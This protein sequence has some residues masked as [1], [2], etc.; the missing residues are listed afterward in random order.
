MD[1]LGTKRPVKRLLQHSGCSEPWW[2][3]WRRATDLRDI[4]RIEGPEG[5]RYGGG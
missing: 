4:I 3:G 2:R 5:F 1:S